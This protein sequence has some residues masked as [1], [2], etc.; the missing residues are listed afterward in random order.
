MAL[1]IFFSVAPFSVA[2]VAGQ[3]HWLL[4]ESPMA[5]LGYG[6]VGAVIWAAYY[7]VR[8]RSQTL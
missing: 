5:A 7:W 3:T 6:S 2:H 8:R 4:L 1:A